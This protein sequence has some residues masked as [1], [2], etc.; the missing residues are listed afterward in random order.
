V[1]GE[2]GL[3]KALGKR[4]GNRAAVKELNAP[5]AEKLGE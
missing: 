2:N 3:R 1:A 5:L 4:A